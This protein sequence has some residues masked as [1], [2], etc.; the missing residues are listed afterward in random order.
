MQRLTRILGPDAG[1]QVF[2]RALAKLGIDELKTPDDLYAFAQVVA[3]FG[4]IEAAVGGLL[5][6]DAVMRGAV[7][8]RR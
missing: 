2:A 5:G 6:V 1:R 7:E 3:G 8:R 4:P